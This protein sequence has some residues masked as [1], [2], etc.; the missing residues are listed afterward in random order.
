[1]KKNKPSGLVLFTKTYPYESGESFIENEIEIASKYY[2]D[3]L[4]VAC[5]V[6]DF[7]KMRST[8]AN[9]K[10]VPI[11]ALSKKEILLNG[12]FREVLRSKE[13]RNEWKN[14]N[15][16]FQRFFCVYFYNKVK[17]MESECGNIVQGFLEN[18]STCMF[19]SYWFFDLAY[20]ALRLKVK[21]QRKYNIHFVSRAHG[22]DLYEERNRFG[23]FPFRNL[24]LEQIDNVFPC[25]LNGTHYLQKRYPQYQNKIE[26]SYLG[27]QDMGAETIS[28]ERKIIILVTCSSLIPLKRVERLPAVLAKLERGGYK[29][30]W[31]CFGDGSERKKI[32]DSCHRLLKDTEVIFKGNVENREVLRF[33]KEEEVDIF[34]NL[35]TTEGLPVSIMEA[36]SFGIPAIATNVGGTS[37][38]VETGY[39]GIL[40]KSDF[41]DHELEEAIIRIVTADDE[42]KKRLRIYCRKFWEQYF[43]NIVNYEAF[44]T[45]LLKVGDK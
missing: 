19:Y 5:Q 7:S 43:N 8:P 26:K 23:Y 9:V 1:M 10:V 45:K 12:S 11:K 16:I 39:T 6:N 18:R 3:I 13:L 20:L 28:D 37:E 42:S 36:L 27:T 31:I 21:F 17:Y 30:R 34:I 15:N 40:L 25:S 32:E 2:D 22:Y 41:L 38:V 33:Y 35:S 24:I 14:C 29:I 4:I 44:Y